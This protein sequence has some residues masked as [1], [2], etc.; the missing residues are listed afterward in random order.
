MHLHNQLRRNRG[1]AELV[2]GVVGL[3]LIIGFTIVAVVLLINILAASYNKEKLGFVTDMAAVYGSNLPPDTTNAPQLIE[4][5]V[6]L[7]LNQMSVKTTTLNVTSKWNDHSAAG[8]IGT[9]PA[10]SVTIDATVPTLLSASLPAFMPVNIKMSDTSI[11]LMRPW[12]WSYGSCSIAAAVLPGWITPGLNVTG[13][14]PKDNKP[15]CNVILPE[16]VTR[17]HH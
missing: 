2:E 10:C 1:A 15:V 6:R 13:Y 12:N 8:K 16:L 3:W 17:G 11:A 7:L 5:R 4:D 14:V 9:R